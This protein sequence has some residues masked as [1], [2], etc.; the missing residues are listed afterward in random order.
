M[1]GAIEAGTYTLCTSTSDLTAGAHY[2]TANVTVTINFAEQAS[3]TYLDNVQSTSMDGNY[4]GSYIVPA[5]TDKS[6]ATSGTCEQVHYH[7]V[8]WVS[9][10]NK[11]NPTDANIVKS[12]TAMTGN[13]TTYYAVWAKE[14]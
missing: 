3:D 13:G 11:S 7:F 8:G 14:E 9:A 2:M 1:W 4:C 5:I 12:G 10:A 6:Q